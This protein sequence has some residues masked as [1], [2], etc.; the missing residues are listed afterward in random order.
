MSLRWPLDLRAAEAP[1]L[2]LTLLTALALA[3]A[4]AARAKAQESTPRD[5]L[6]TT[7]SGVV[8][9]SLTGK[10]LAGAIVQLVADR[11]PAKV[12]GATSGTD[13]GFQMAGISPGSYIIG[14]L[15]P[16]LD[17]LGL[18]V[19]PR[20]LEIASSAPVN[21]ALAVPSAATVRDRLCAPGFAG[22]STGML[23]GF[24]RDADRGVPLASATVVVMWRELVIQNGVHARRREIPV[25]TN[26]EGWYALCGVPTDGPITARAELGSHSSGFV[27]ISVAPYR[28]LHRDFGI[29]GDSAVVKVA[30]DDSAGAA[31]SQ[32]VRRGSARLTGTV[33][34]ERGRPLSGAQLLVWGSG[35]TGSTRED[36]SFM[37]VSLPAGSQTLEVRYVG[38]APDR[39]TVDLVSRATRSVAVTLDR[40]ADVLGEVTIYGEPSERRRDLTGFVQRSKSGFGHFLTRADIEKRHPFEFSDLFDM[41][42]GFRV[43]RDTSGI[44][45]ILSKRGDN[46]SGPCEP[47]FYINGMKLTKVFEI[48]ALIVPSDIAAMEA[49]ADPAGAPTQDI[50]DWCGSILIWTG[51]DLRITRD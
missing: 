42:P 40:H 22:D 32:T 43:V 13:G 26:G 50:A 5:T 12:V 25:K 21:V 28:M 35:V 27:E 3:V 14:F 7:V 30:V 16:A 39:V 44:R 33:S 49:Y 19:A 51:N 38:Y 11:N 31:A 45:R 10:P 29:P 24:V 41:I 48:D 37:L 15:H 9:D 23:I 17:S 36:G 4:P 1:K 6:T 47:T 46:I 8:F 18:V 2:P 34:D 20:P